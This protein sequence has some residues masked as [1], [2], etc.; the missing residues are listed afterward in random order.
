MEWEGW[1]VSWWIALR[2]FEPRL[3][4]S[5]RDGHVVIEVSLL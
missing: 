2:T 5:E 1:G 3:D 4:R